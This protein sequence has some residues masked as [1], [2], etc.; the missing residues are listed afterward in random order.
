MT[1]QSNLPG[2]GA[3]GEEP[4]PPGKV[5]VD[6][7]PERLRLL[8]GAYLY[9]HLMIAGL[10]AYLAG[11]GLASIADSWPWGATIALLMGVGLAAGWR[12][13][14]PRTALVVV[15]ALTVTGLSGA[16]I[17]PKPPAPPPDHLVHHIP[18][19][20]ITLEGW[21][22]EESVSGGRAHQVRL[23]AEWLGADSDRR[24]ASGDLLVQLPSHHA[25]A[26]GQRL[27]LTGVHLSRPD[28]Y[29]NPGGFDYRE[30][31]ARKGIYLVGRLRAGGAVE[32]LSGIHPQASFIRLYVSR[33]RAEM[34]SA[35]DRAIPGD[36]GAVLQAIVLGARERLS[37]RVRNQFRRTGTAHLLA[38]SGLHVG[39]IA[40]LAFWGLRAV[41]RIVL[42]LTPE[43]YGL[44]LAPSRWAALGTAPAILFYA[45]LVGGRVATIRA[46]IMI[47][48]Y[49]AAR[50]CRKPSN[51][52]HALALAAILILIW[53]P[54]SM[55]DV[56]FQLSFTA[57]TAILLA[58]RARERSE[59][60]QIPTGEKTA[61]N[62]IGRRAGIFILISVVASR[63]TWPLIAKTFH[64]V[65]LVGPLTNTLVVPLASLT[66]PLGLVAA[67]C[68]LLVPASAQILFAPAGWGAS[69]LL[70]IL[71]TLSGYPHASMV[72]AAPSVPAIIAY[73][74]LLASLL[75]W[76]LSRRRGALA[77]AAG[78]IVL[79]AT[80]AAALQSHRVASRLTIIA[81]DAGRA[82]AILIRLPDERTLLWFGAPPHSPRSLARRVV[83]PALLDQRI[84]AIDGLIAANATEETAKGLASLA[85]AVKVHELWVAP[86]ADGTWPAPLRRTIE[87]LG[88][89][90]QALGAGWSQ[91][92]GAACLIR[93][94]WPRA[95]ATPPPPTRSADGPVLHVRLN[96]HSALLTGD[97]SFRVERA[98]LDDPQAVRASMLQVPKAGSR[99]ASNYSFLRMVAPEVAVLAARFP[100]SWLEDVEKTLER[101]RR[102][103]IRLW[104]VD[105]DGA[106][107]WQTDGTTSSIR[108]VRFNGGETR[109]LRSG[110]AGDRDRSR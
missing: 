54:K 35:M 64:R 9:Q 5:E 88:L 16:W 85:R 76:P 84:G 45:L 30:F 74:T 1:A 101:Y 98:L 86:R 70:T 82:Q 24:P 11:Y 55:W 41:I 50:V 19:G 105:R 39:F 52:F 68:S 10:A 21:V 48:V 23:R 4:N 110:G 91:P 34:L 49:L 27:R 69:L 38:I 33:W 26:Y 59:A 20:P 36:P 37:R 32:I 92:C 42:R 51:N 106:I 29:A 97:S 77:F 104:R 94:L 57:V 90:I 46:T 62:R 67:L 31:L 40:A 15:A 107:T 81:L 60:S 66:I 28:G 47:F 56:G 65:A 17:Q 63:A 73:Y 96:R 18:E 99:Y 3:R 103:G 12:A 2:D 93:I 25:L 71:E 102:M 44:R 87:E 7:W 22:A 72:V 89:P 58:L 14:L 78:I 53:D 109:R 13:G 80:T 61:L 79:G 83:V 8:A 6:R 100:V 43:M 108:A 95:G 75:A